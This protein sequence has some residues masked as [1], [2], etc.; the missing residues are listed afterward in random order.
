M[1]NNILLYRQIGYSVVNNALGSLFL[2]TNLNL[3][4]TFTFVSLAEVTEGALL[5]DL[6]FVFQNIDGQYIQ[7]DSHQDAFRLSSKVCY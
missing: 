6:I 1:L 7:F 3:Y 5:R 2:A 4:T